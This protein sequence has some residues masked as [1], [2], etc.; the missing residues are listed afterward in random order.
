VLPDHPDLP[1]P[2]I[3][4]YLMDIT[5]ARDIDQLLHLALTRINKLVSF[6]HAGILGFNIPRKVVYRETIGGSESCNRAFQDYYHRVMPDVGITVKRFGV[7][8]WQ[9]YH[10]TEYVT[11]FS[12]PYNIRYSAGITNFGQS[13]FGDLSLSINRSNDL[14]RFTETELKTLEIVQGHL[15]N[16]LAMFSLATQDLPYP[17]AEDIRSAFPLL[18]PRESEVTALLCQRYPAEYIASRLMISPLTVNKHIENIFI[19]MK[20]NCRKELWVKILGPEANIFNHI[21]KS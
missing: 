20:V 8:D 18:T 16:F 12:R 13:K 10:H 7:T 4:D 6:D 9:D 2:K 14:P 5:A 1:W 21:P 19:K 15:T 17:D 11:D 3:N